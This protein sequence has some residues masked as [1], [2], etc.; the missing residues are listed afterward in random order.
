MAASIT[1]TPAAAARP[2][3]CQQK[4]IKL[5]NVRSSTDQQVKARRKLEMPVTTAKVMK[6]TTPNQPIAPVRAPPSFFFRTTTGMLDF[7]ALI[8]T[9]A[10]VDN[11]DFCEELFLTVDINSKLVVQGLSH[12]Y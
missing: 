10:D 7:I 1:S 6:E 11:M 3:T 4:P 12:L 5:Q 2:S 8:K 9:V